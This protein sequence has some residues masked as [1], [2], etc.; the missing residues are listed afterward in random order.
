MVYTCNGCVCVNKHGFNQ[1]LLA[2]CN[3][4][5][6]YSL[7]INRFYTN[8]RLSMLSLQEGKVFIRDLIEKGSNATRYRYCHL[9]ATPIAGIVTFYY[10]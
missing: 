6:K 7:T 5:V 8:I 3:K 10:N 4:P 9:A 1:L 2:F